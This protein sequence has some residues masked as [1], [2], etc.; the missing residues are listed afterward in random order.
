MTTTRIVITTPPVPYTRAVTT[1]SRTTGKPIRVHSDRYRSWRST[2]RD[3]FAILRR[4]RTIDGPVALNLEVHPDQLVA[5]FVAVGPDTRPAG[6]RG[7]LDNYIKA[8]LD[9]AQ[10][11][12][13]LVDDRHVVAITARFVDS[14]GSQ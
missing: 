11:G 7:D 2:A 8:V 3:T 1:V 14:E 6:L 12:G 10:S 4:G 13:L 5:E 9:A